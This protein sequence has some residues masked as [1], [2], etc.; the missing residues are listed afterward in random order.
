MGA[1]HLLGHAISRSF[2]RQLQL[3]DLALDL[4]RRLTEGQF[5]ELGDRRRKGPATQLVMDAEVVSDTRYS[6]RRFFWFALAAGIG[7]L[8]AMHA[9]DPVGVLIP[10]WR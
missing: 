5:L 4:F 6:L 8:Q 9:A 1:F 3:F 7:F 10:A 2:E